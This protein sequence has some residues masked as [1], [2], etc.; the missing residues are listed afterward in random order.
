[1]NSLNM[2]NDKNIFVS[3]GDKNRENFNKS[4]KANMVHIYML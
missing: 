2:I 3:P 1:M 4:L